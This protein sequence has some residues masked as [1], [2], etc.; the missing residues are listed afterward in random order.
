MACGQGFAQVSTVIDELRP[1]LEARSQAQTN[2]N[3]IYFI[4]LEFC[5]SKMNE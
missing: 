2:I 1:L 4:V 5:L 3:Y